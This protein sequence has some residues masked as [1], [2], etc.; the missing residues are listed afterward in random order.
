MTLLRYLSNRSV[1]LQWNVDRLLDRDLSL[2]MKLIV[3]IVLIFVFKIQYTRFGNKKVL[4]YN[5]A[6]AAVYFAALS[7]G[8]KMKLSTPRK[9]H[10]SAEIAVSSIMMNN[11]FGSRN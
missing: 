2:M 6:C 5:I 7:L 9:I 4:A 1:W 11:G 8:M 10:L 3:G